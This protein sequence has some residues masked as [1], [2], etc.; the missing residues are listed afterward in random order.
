[1]T[2]RPVPVRTPSDLARPGVGRIALPGPS[3]PLGACA[4]SWLESLG[5]GQVLSRALV[6]DNAG[7][8]AAALRAKQA[9]V[10]L[11]YASDVARAEGW[12]VLFRVRHP[13]VVIRYEAS[14]LTCGD[15]PEQAQAVLEFL[16]STEAAGRFRGCGLLPAR[17]SRA[18]GGA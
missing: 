7:A 6:L 18:R 16:T 17:A 8:V 9:D 14:V 10:G 4:R 2:G 1:V 12:R 3:C 5:L 15:M 13:S 11:V